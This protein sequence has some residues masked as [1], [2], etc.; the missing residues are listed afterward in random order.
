MEIKF[1]LMFVVVN[2]FMILVSWQ[3][4]TRFLALCPPTNNLH[5]RPVCIQ[6]FQYWNNIT[7]NYLVSKTYIVS[8]QHFRYIMM[9]TLVVN[10][11]Y[12]RTHIS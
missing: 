1:H 6:N 3:F 4:R 2:L 8:F 11:I 7:L 9:T 10:S 5:S 12:R